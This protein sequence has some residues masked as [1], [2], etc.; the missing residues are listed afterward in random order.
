NAF[1]QT[2]SICDVSRRGAR[3]HGIGCLRGPGETIEVEHRSKKARF[4]VV[5]VGLPGTLEAD[6]IGIRLLERN[7]SIWALDLPKPHRDDFIQPETDASKKDWVPVWDL[8]TETLLDSDQVEND[9]PQTDSVAFLLQQKA[10]Q[11]PQTTGDR[12]QYRRYAVDGGAEL[13]ARG[14]D[15]RTWGRRTDI[16]TSGCY[17]EMYVP[18]AA[19]TE[20]EMILEVGQVRIL[21]DGIVKVVYPGL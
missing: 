2:A 9:V 7:K 21:A 12:R 18:P 14:S 20:L 11:E 3:V 6:H 16:S 15:T 10:L 8:E 5:W 19:G 17:V 4:F 1:S 13:C